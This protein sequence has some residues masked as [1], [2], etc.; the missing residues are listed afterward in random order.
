MN[1]EAHLSVWKL[2]MSKSL[3][4]L[5]IGRSFVSHSMSLLAFSFLSDHFWR[6]EEQYY[7]LQSD[8]GSRCSASEL[9]QGLPRRL[10]EVTQLKIATQ[11]N[12]SC[13]RATYFSNLRR[14]AAAMASASI[15]LTECPHRG[16]SHHSKTRNPAL[17][18]ERRALARSAAPLGPAFL[19]RPAPRAP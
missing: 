9:R 8:R 7:L 18:T 12:P 1:A 14:T 16:R 15:P 5:A 6:L 3:F 4:S 13:C 19:L 10:C 17:G 2:G 11:T